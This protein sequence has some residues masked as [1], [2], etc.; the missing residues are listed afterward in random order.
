M[1]IGVLVTISVTCLLSLYATGAPPG[2]IKV[3]EDTFDGTTLDTESWTIGLRDPETGDIVPGAVG[4]RLLNWGYAGYNTDEDVLVSG[5]NLILLNQKRSYAGTDPSGAFEYTT[6]W[7]MT[8]HKVHFNK[9]YVEMR[10]KYPSGDKVW[11]A[12]WLIAEDLVWGPEWD[13]F[14]YFGFRPDVGYDEMGMHLAYGTYPNISWLGNWLLDYHAAYDAEAWHVYGFEWTANYA[15]WYID[16]VEVA[17][18]DNTIGKDWPDE[19]MYIVLNNGVRTESPDRNTTWPNQLVVDYIAVHQVNNECGDG[20]CEPGEDCRSCLEDCSGMT[21]GKP[22]NRYCCGNG[23]CED[24]E[25]ETTCAVDCG[26]GP[27][28]GDG[29]C[30]IGEDVCSCSA[31]CGLGPGWETSCTNELDDDCDGDTDCA[32]SE[33]VNDPTCPTCGDRTCSDSERCSCVDDC[34]AHPP[35]ETNCD[36]GVDDDCDGDVDCSDG[37]CSVTPVCVGG[38]VLFADDFESGTFATGGWI[39]DKAQVHEQAAYLATYGVKF[40]RQASIEKPLST[41]GRSGIS[42]VYDRRTVNYDPEDFFLV[43]WFDGSL[44][45]SLEKT[46]DASWG[47][48]SFTLPSGADDN[49]AFRIRFIAIGNRPTDKVFL[50]NVEIVD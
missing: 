21:R 13:L 25:N 9:G 39:V 26:P 2:Y 19:E 20:V 17:R 18:L 50:D 34:G 16:G 6:G 43:E 49:P 44:W 31:D 1:K 33:C 38:T 8:L 36:D 23:I 22:A 3:W 46:Q 28:C 35:E 24:M 45:H 47:H 14:E 11:P 15:K 27:T 4:G 30:D 7:I 48:T 12:L 41:A 40:Q 37:E 29:H 32:D 10:A 5:G 42:V